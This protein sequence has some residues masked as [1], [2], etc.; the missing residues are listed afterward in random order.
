LDLNGYFPFFLGTIAN[1]W[2][3]SSSRIYLREFGVGIVEWR[4]L[5]S[6]RAFE[7]ATSLD[8]GNLVGSD[9]AA[10]S[11][12]IRNLESRGLVIPVEGRFPGRTKPYQLTSEGRALFERIREVALKREEIL[13]QDL[14][15]EERIQFLHLLKKVHARLKDIQAD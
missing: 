1:K 3:S 6:L 12:G 14:D 8:I 5:V 13:V 10:I 4:I 7:T 11:R 15:Q 9:P 2:T